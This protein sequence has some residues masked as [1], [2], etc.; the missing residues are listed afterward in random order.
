[1]ITGYLS[2][3]ETNI[4]WLGLIPDNWEIKRVKDLADYQSGEYINSNEFDDDATYPV[5]GGNGFRGL[6]NKYNHNGD[7]IL[8]GRQGALC[9]NI[10]YASGKFWATEHAVVVYKKKLVNFWWL[11]EVLRVMNLNQ[12]SLSAAQPGLSVDKIK[13]LEVPYPPFEEQ[14]TIAKYLEAESYKI[15]KTISLLESKA[16]LHRSLSKVIINDTIRKGFTNGKKTIDSQI[17]RIGLIPNN[18]KVKRLKDI[19]Y[20]YSGLTGK[21]GEDFNQEYTA[22]TKN[23]IPFTNIANNKYI[24]HKDLHTVLFNTNEKQNRVKKDDLFFLMSSESFADIGKAALLSEDLK[25][26]YLNSFCKGYRVTNKAVSPAYLNYLLNSPS[27]RERLIVEGKGFTRINLKMEKVNDFKII[28]PPLDEQIA[29]VNYLDEKTKIID[30]IIN[31]INDQIIN[32]K[33]LKV[34]LFNQVLTGK[35]KIV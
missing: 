7:Y 18:W 15:E 1:M 5:Y 2:Y 33:K 35:L 6:A 9:G 14:N 31:N 12:Y 24:D 25:D 29:I 20:L 4:P 11:G 27:F 32:L 23:Y 26:T 28:I 17:E 22:N 16:S 8:I 10:N 30:V 13:R 21:T 34:T 19:G 3:K